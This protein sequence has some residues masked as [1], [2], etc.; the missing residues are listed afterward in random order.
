MI[1]V[2]RRKGIGSNIQNIINAARDNVNA[3]IPPRGKNPVKYNWAG[4][5]GAGRSSPTGAVITAANPGITVIEALDQLKNLARETVNLIPDLAESFP[6]GSGTIIMLNKK[7]WGGPKNRMFCTEAVIYWFNKGGIPITYLPPDHVPPKFV[8]ENYFDDSL[9][10][11]SAR[12]KNK[13]KKIFEN[14]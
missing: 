10:K 6:G 8:A 3:G 14:R 7:I 11:V 5:A 4:L 2:K 13:V 1:L 12:D 9:E